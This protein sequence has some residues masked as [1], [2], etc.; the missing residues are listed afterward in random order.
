MT[1]PVGVVTVKSY[2]HVVLDDGQ[3][4][5]PTLAGYWYAGEVFPR[6]IVVAAGIDRH[7]QYVRLLCWEAL[8]L[9]IPGLKGT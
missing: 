6:G 1:Q 7:G 5:L 2:L 4:W 3:Q 9:V 8:D